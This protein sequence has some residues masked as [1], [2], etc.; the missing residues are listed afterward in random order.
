MA[1]GSSIAL[2]LKMNYKS[3]MSDYPLEQGTSFGSKQRHFGRIRWKLKCYGTGTPSLRITFW[4]SR[5][6]KIWIACSPPPVLHCSC[7]VLPSASALSSNHPA[8][9]VVPLS[10]MPTVNRAVTV[11]SISWL[12]SHPLVWLFG[13]GR[14]CERSVERSPIS[15]FCPLSA[16]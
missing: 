3:M 15:R 7:V 1:A 13:C 11:G 12:R 9:N 2:L 4:L 8:N 16:H 5:R 10:S 14:S 6:V